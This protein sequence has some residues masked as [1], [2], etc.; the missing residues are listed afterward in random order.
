LNGISNDIANRPLVA[1]RI[2]PDRYM[3][4]GIKIKSCF[5]LD[6][7][8]GLLLQVALRLLMGLRY[9]WGIP[10]IGH[11][12]SHMAH[13]LYRGFACLPDQ[14]PA[15][16]ASRAANVQSSLFWAVQAAPLQ[17]YE[18]HPSQPYLDHLGKC[19]VSPCLAQT[20]LLSWTV[21]SP[22]TWSCDA[23]GALEVEGFASL[24]MGSTGAVEHA[25]LVVIMI[26]ITTLSSS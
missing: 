18:R 24:I 3:K 10:T 25:V 9:Q 4:R 26:I 19:R 21:S 23:A 5:K 6:K 20:A 1:I 14:D 8:S 7:T 22:G 12:F 16:A 13:D 15:G 17:T 11:I 2:N